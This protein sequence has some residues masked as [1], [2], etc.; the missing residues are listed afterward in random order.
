MGK[1]SQDIRVGKSIPKYKLLPRCPRCHK[2]MAHVEFT[3]DDLKKKLNISVD[4]KEPN[5]PTM[6]WV[7][8][9]RIIDREDI[10]RPVAEYGLTLDRISVFD[11]HDTHKDIRLW[12]FNTFKGKLQTKVQQYLQEKGIQVWDLKKLLE[13]H[14]KKYEGREVQMIDPATEA[15]RMIA[16][17]MEEKFNGN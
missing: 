8:M 12:K 2:I 14:A 4:S 1:R 13:E 9:G 3:N 17:N 15:E 5:K 16:E 6:A 11:S 10:I 7:C